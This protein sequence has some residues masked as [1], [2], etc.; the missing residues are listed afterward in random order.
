MQLR[1]PLLALAFA[2]PLSF[3]ACARGLDGGVFNGGG[4]G[5]GGA[6]G[7]GDD[8]TSGSG[9]SSAGKSTTHGSS[10]AGQPSATSSTGTGAL[11]ICGDAYC[12]GSETCGNCPGD[13]GACPGCGDGKCQG[14]ETCN[15]CPDDCGACASCGD[16]TCNPGE[17]CSSCQAD[18]GPCGGACGDGTCAGGETCASCQ[19]DCGP[20]GGGACSHDPCKTGA[21]L[22]SGCDPCVT[23]VCSIDPFCCDDS[24]DETC[25]EEVEQVCGKSCGGVGGGNCSHDLCATGSALTP[26]CDPCVSDICSVD[27]Y[28][29]TTSWDAQCV[30]EVGTICG[31]SCG[32]G[33]CAHDP[34]TIGIA[35]TPNCDPCV[36]AVCAIDDYCCTEEWD[37]LCVDEVATECGILCF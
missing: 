36:S 17:T 16:G 11:P 6:G 13:C 4:D 37:S 20:C 14:D 18:C 2:L 21:A 19:I 24:W 3:A 29:C 1:R 23:D 7:A 32:G 8:E 12:E 33:S 27:S 25:V 30:Q 10:G 5:E 26:N 31:Q 28:C 22:S 9:S 15:A 34:C 35:L